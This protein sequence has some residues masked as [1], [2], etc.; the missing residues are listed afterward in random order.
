M[1]KSLTVKITKK[2]L[3]IFWRKKAVKLGTM[4]LVSLC[5]PSPILTFIG[6]EA[7]TLFY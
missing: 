7:L 3:N 4:A 6:M 1:I 5:S 2:V